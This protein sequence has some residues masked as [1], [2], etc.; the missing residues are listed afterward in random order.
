[1]QLVPPAL[2]VVEAVEDDYV[3]VGEHTLDGAVEA[4][5]RIL[6]RGVG[7]ARVRGHG[8]EIVDGAGYGQAVVGDEVQA[9]LRVG[10]TSREVV[11]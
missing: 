5:A 3:L 11:V 2:D 1:M 4:G 7:G 10:D 9:V 6:F 8:G